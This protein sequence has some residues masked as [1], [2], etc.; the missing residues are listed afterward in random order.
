MR[1]HYI[2]EG[3]EPRPAQLLEWATWFETA[4]RT[5]ARSEV[6]GLTI[7]TV[8]M[9]LNQSMGIGPPLLFE[10]MVFD[11][12]EP[13]DSMQIRYATWAEAETGHMDIC[14][15]LIEMDNLSKDMMIKSIERRGK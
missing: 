7:S 2:L 12:T 4:N 14:E 13:I 15:Q 11:E 5:V 1:Y 3:K 10:T 6:A 8:F 9:G